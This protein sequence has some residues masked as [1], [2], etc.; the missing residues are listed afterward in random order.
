MEEKLNKK[1]KLIKKILDFIF[2]FH[3]L[4]K[5]EKKNEKTQTDDIYPMW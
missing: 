2:S 5:K 3:F 1:K 4:K